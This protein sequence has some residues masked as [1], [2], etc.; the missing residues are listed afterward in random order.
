VSQESLEDSEATLKAA[1]ARAASLVAQIEQAQSTLDGD[2]TN[3]SYTRIYAPIDGTVVSQS[4]REGQ[5]L[6]ANQQAPVILQL[7]NLDEMSVRA[8]VAEADIMRLK[9]G[10]P[11]YFTTLGSLERRWQG[12]VRQILPSPEIINDVVLY[13]ALVDVDNRDRQLMTGM[14]TQ[15]FFVLG[16][17]DNVPVIP[18]GALGK[19]M[20]AQDNERGQAYQVRVKSGDSVTEKTI[21]VG[22]MSR[23]YAEVRTGLASGDQVAVPT[24]PGSDQ[25]SRQP[26][27]MPMRL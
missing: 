6:N 11:V 8:Q 21:H 19:R 23:Q 12:T 10:T 2:E 13:N 4:A 26:R 17:A 3:L 25:G 24:T 22:L 9:P 27:R 15:M 18:V 7:A 14:S 5:T 1:H 20:S 16:E